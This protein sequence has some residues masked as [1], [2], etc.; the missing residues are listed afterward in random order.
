[1]ER[2]RTGTVALV[3]RDPK[4]SDEPMDNSRV[5]LLWTSEESRWLI[6]QAIR[7]NGG[8]VQTPNSPLSRQKEAFP[9][10]EKASSHAV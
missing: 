3:T 5:V 8:F 6:G 2:T 7:V 4:A 9:M 1:M 10:K